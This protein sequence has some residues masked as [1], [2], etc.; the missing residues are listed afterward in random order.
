MKKIIAL[1]SA[2]TVAALLFASCSKE[3]SEVVP[4]VTE[5]PTEPITA[6]TNASGE[7]IFPV[8][9]KN[10]DALRNGESVAVHVTDANGNPDAKL[11]EWY[12]LS[13]A[14]AIGRKIEM[15]SFRITVPQG[16]ADARSTV[17]VNIGNAETLDMISV[18]VVSDKTLEEIRDEIASQLSILGKR[19]DSAIIKTETVMIGGEE[20]R[21]S[22]GFI[23][24]DASAVFLGYINFS[25]GGEVYDC[26]LTA[27]RDL[28]QEEINEMVDILK[29][30]EFV[31]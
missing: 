21:F 23:K 12:S 4:S 26:R 29:S 24:T 20:A 25:H 8:T 28:S 11:T 15:P 3:P 2:L 5:K 17:Q 22:S 18:E 13:G 7:G 31:R 30:I 9:D 19:H 6:V 16:W 1:L 14:F 27:D 10:G